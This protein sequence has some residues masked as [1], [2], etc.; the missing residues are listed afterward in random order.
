MVQESKQ[1]LMP[2]LLRSIWVVGE[3]ANREGDYALRP[4]ACVWT[5]SV[6]VQAHVVGGVGSADDIAIH[7]ACDSFLVASKGQLYS[8]Q[9]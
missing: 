1:I 4:P 2:Y 3:V 8:R 9:R 6:S 7:F 5:V